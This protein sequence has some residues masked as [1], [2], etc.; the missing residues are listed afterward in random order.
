MDRAASLIS[1]GQDYTFASIAVV[2]TADL[3]YEVGI[4]RN[5]VKLGAATEKVPIR[6]RVTTV[7]RRE[8][9]EWKIVHRHAD[10]ITEERSVQSL[11]QRVEH[12][13]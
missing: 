7:F 6:L 9:A 3:A 5:T 4:E 1:A 13:S 2:E 8:G 12:P 10:P 11:T